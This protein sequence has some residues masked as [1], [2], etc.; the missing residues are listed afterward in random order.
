MLH[1][2]NFLAVCLIYVTY[3]S[4]KYLFYGFWVGMLLIF[5]WF[6][7]WASDDFRQ[8]VVLISN[9][10]LKGEWETQM[11]IFLSMVCS[12]A[13]ASKKTFRAKHVF[14]FL[15]FLQSYSM[16]ALS[17]LCI[18]RVYVHGVSLFRKIIL[19]RKKNVPSLSP[20]TFLVGWFSYSCSPSNWM[21]SHPTYCTCR[22]SM[23]VTNF[24][25]VLYGVCTADVCMCFLG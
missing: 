12:C 10:Q 9:E 21:Q 15:L 14:F 8:S 25:S 22:F 11:E 2:E 3:F 24:Q 5:V 18:L 6:S 1:N 7:F 17:R 4:R 20:Y 16:M 19:G 23:F 13:G